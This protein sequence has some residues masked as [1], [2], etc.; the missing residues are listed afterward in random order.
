VFNQK[1][2][3]YIEEKVGLNLE[4]IR[5]K[6]PNKLRSYIEKKSGKPIKF[7]TGEACKKLITRKELNRQIDFFL[8]R[9]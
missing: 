2:A 3:K 9:M 6:S 8:S 5:K 7:K 1:L 4:E